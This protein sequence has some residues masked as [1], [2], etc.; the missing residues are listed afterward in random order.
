[1]KYLKKLLILWVLFWILASFFY[2]STL[3]YQKHIEIRDNYVQHP[4]G[5]PTPEVAKYTSFWFANLRANLFW[6]QTVQYIGWNAVSSEYKKYLYAITNLTTELNPYFEHPYIITLLLLP[7]VN[8]RYEDVTKESQN[9]NTDDAVKI[10]LKWIENFCTA[11]DENWNLKIDLIRWEK[12]LS[13]IWSEDKYKNPCKSYK[14]PYYLAYVYYYYK[15]DPAT[16]SDYYKIASANDDSVEWAKSMAAIMA[17][18]WW[19]REKSIFMFLNIASS[20]D[21]DKWVC[22]EFSKELNNISSLVFQQKKIPLSGNLVQAIENS[23]IATFGKFNGDDDKQIS[24]TSCMNFLNKANREINMAYVEQANQKYK[25]E[26][27]W[28]N[29]SDAQELFDKKYLDF[30]PTD[31]QQYDEKDYGIRYEFNEEL[32]RFDYVMSY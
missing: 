14:I 18:K 15:N 12:S 19:D 7:S 31:F 13:K 16:A 2:I 10:G 21:S 11:K 4:D 6:L 29:A 3:N 8:Q 17:G 28:E 27:N 9:K 5:L 1:M 32:G 30:L 20:L 26:N 24:D 23:R 25:Q 22:S